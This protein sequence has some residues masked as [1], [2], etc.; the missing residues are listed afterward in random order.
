M[1]HYPCY[2]FSMGPHTPRGSAELLPYNRRRPL[3]LKQRC[4]WALEYSAAATTS[5]IW[6]R[7]HLNC[8][9]TFPRSLHH[10]VTSALLSESIQRYMVRVPFG[11]RWSFVVLPQTSAGSPYGRGRDGE[12]RNEKYSSAP[13]REGTGGGDKKLLFPPEGREKGGLVANWDG[14]ARCKRS[15]RV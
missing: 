1:L 9:R 13:P 6:T 2:S 14:E 7:H 11:G 15:A 12:A 8:N 3:S 4:S 5:A 10:S